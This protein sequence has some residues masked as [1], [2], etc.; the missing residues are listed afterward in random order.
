LNIIIINSDSDTR[1]A[2]RDILAPF[3]DL[4]KLVA[5]VATVS[6]GTRAIQ[7]AHPTVLILGVKEI[8]E[9][10][11][12]VQHI[13]TMFPR[14]SIYVTAME[15]SS[16]W[17]LKLMRAGATEYFLEPVAAE[18]LKAALQKLG[19]LWLTHAP[20]PASVGKIISAYNPIGGMGTTTVAVN[21]AACLASESDK[22]ALVD[23]NLFSGD[24][25]SFLDL[26]PT[27][28]LSSVTSNINRLDASFLKTVLTRHSSGMYVLTEPSEVDDCVVITPEQVHRILEFFR[29]I[30]DYVVVDTGG[31]LAGTNL[32][33]MELSDRLLFVTVLNLPSLRNAKRYLT[34]LARLGFNKSKVKLVV[35]RYTH[36]ADI[37]IK[38]AEQVLDYSVFHSIPNEY[39]DVV[40]SINKGEPVVKMLPRSAVCKSMT[41][42]ADLV[43]ESIQK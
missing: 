4:V 38:D 22:V 14:L 6:E 15:K 39:H 41:R 7:Q 28:T 2:L 31:Y 43:K 16:D 20:P 29:G 13:L 37:N 35:N 30:F 8:D 5:D 26:N 36:S 11:A 21:L 17:I 32:T 42:L 19:R 10:V 25:A 12:D 27:Y 23:L 18:E 40:A 33:C 34:A 9:G 1:K 3:A 24:V